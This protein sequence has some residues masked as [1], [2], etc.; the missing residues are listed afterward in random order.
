MAA[1]DYV[2]RAGKDFL[3]VLWY[4]VFKNDIGDFLK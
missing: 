2:V 3:T 4:L 1:Q